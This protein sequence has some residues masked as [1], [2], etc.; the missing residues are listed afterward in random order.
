MAIGLALPRVVDGG[1]EVQQRPARALRVEREVVAQLGEEGL[2]ERGVEQRGELLARFGMEGGARGRGQVALQ[3]GR[4]D[5]ALPE[6]GPRLQGRQVLRAETTRVAWEAGRNMSI[7]RALDLALAATE[8]PTS[9]P[10]GPSDRSVRH[11]ARLSPREREV[12]A[13]L[14]Q[15]LS[16][17]QIAHQLVVTERTVAAH[18][19]H[20]LDKLGF[21]SRHQVGAWAD[22][23][24]LSG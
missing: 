2:H 4:G 8:A 1:H 22:E 24:G 6:T 10:N 21:A 5:P 9:R 16:N 18:I 15:G 13:L 20:I 11:V 12:A 3:E 23:H 7:E 14:G 17:R 19:E